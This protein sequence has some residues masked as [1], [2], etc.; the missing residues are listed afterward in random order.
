MPVKENMYM[1]KSGTRLGVSLLHGHTQYTILCFSFKENMY[2]GGG[3]HL[4]HL[5]QFDQTLLKSTHWTV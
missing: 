2:R 1:S 4:V 3:V 5:K